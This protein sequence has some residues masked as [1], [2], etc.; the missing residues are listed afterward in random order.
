MRARG[1]WI[2]MVGLRVMEME[3]SV[4]IMG[5]GGR[6]SWDFIVGLDLKW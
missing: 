2:E 3:T 5:G 6:D 1:C 4:F